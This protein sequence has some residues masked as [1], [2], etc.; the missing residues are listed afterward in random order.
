[1]RFYIYQNWV[2]SIASS[3]GRWIFYVFPAEGEL[4]SDCSLHKSSEEALGRALEYIDRQN[5]RRL[6]M[7]ALDIL[8]EK[9]EI[10]TDLYIQL[11]RRLRDACV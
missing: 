3:N 8:L 11:V 7:T 2:I 6:I 9:K 4:L 1:M 5:A 10:D